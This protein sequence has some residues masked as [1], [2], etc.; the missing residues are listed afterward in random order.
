MRQSD[1]DYLSDSLV[2]PGKSAHHSERTCRGKQE[3]SPTSEF[4]F[5]DPIIGP[6]IRV[7]IAS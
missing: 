2:G 6:V 5:N 3:T 4:E 1:S 7:L